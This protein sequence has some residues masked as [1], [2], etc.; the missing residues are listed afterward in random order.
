MPFFNPVSLFKWQWVMY[1]LSNGQKET[2]KPQRLPVR[3][4]HLNVC[5]VNAQLPS[6][7]VDGLYSF[8]SQSARCSPLSGV[9]TGSITVAQDACSSG[10]RPKKEE[11]LLTSSKEALQTDMMLL[12]QQ[13]GFL[14]RVIKTFES[15]DKGLVLS[16]DRPKKKKLTCVLLTNYNLLL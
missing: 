16:S 1:I 4:I 9:S 13:V 6:F 10:R 3:S 14:W 15:A 12:R 5:F 8:S 7:C 11:C 2:K